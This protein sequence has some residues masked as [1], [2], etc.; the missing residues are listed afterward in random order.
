MNK[1]KISVIVP[2][3]NVE[4]YLS[5]C[6]ESLLSQTI[7]EIEILLLNDG[8]TDASEKIC[9]KFSQMDERV[10]VYS[11]DN[12]GLGETRNKGIEIALGDYLAFVDSDDFISSDG[13]KT[14]YD[15]AIEE[16]LDIVQGETVIFD[17]SI[18]Y[19][20]YNLCGIKNF[21]ISNENSTTFYKDYYF[22]KV[23]SHNAWDK[24]YRASFVRQ[25]DLKFGDNKVIFAEDNWFQL[26]AL[27]CSPN[28]GFAHFKYYYYRQHPESIMHKPKA[29]LV[30]RHGKMI[31]DYKKLIKTKGLNIENK[32][33]AILASDIF[34]MEALNQKMAN[35]K[36][37]VFLKALSDIHKDEAL[38][39]SIVDLYSLQ[40][41]LLEKDKNRRFYLLMVGIGYRFKLYHFTNMLVW[42][43]YSIRG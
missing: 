38:R 15:K 28:I 30:M 33:C 4:K 17:D 1:I 41:Y 12:R 39:S 35:S 10:K 6:V 11:H 18:E 31:S 40:S 16:D 8:S 36:R 3:Y 37:R 26:Q 19:V 25:N 23:Y 14:L 34:T 22:G 2:V 24:L 32:V 27:V 9:M 29:N 7:K 20:R 42:L 5:Q 43:I 13:L 21:K